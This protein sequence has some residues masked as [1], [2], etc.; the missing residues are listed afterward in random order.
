MGPLLVTAEDGAVTA[1]HP[2]DAPPQPPDDPVLRDCERELQAYF[3][4]ALRRF[5]VPLR[6][7]G[8]PFRQA[9]WQAITTIP[10]GVTV[11]YG[12]V[13]RA[14]GK[15]GAARAVGQAIHRN[16]VCILIPCH[17]VIGAHGFVSGYAWGPEVKAR[18]LALEKACVRPD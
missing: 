6:P 18:L 2:T 17:R 11:T 10:Y 16:P 9:V 7:G 4:G 12:D 13:A 3:A 5:T 14:I 15:P 8:T 1:L